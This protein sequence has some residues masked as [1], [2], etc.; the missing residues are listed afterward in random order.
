MWMVKSENGLFGVETI[1]GGK[2][3]CT[4]EDEQSTKGDWIQDI[5]VGADRHSNIF[6]L[7]S[8]MVCREYERP[9]GTLEIKQTT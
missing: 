7:R 2:K 3:M 8:V 5:G 4:N 9:N 6:C 1:G